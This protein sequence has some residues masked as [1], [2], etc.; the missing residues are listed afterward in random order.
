MRFD[1]V[2][3]YNRLRQIEDALK[4]GSQLGTPSAHVFTLIKLPTPPPT[5]PAEEGAGEGSPAAQD[6]KV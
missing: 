4:E 3:L 2:A 1:Y 6:K 5:P